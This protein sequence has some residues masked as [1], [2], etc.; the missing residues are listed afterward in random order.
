MVATLAVLSAL[1][2]ISEALSL[3]PQIQANGVFQAVVNGLKM[4][5]DFIGQKAA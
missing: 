5:K 1:L 2:A 4:I 3:I